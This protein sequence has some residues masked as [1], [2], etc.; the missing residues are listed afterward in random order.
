MLGLGKRKNPKKY[1][2]T[3]QDLTSGIVNKEEIT[4]EKYSTTTKILATTTLGIPGYLKTK[5]NHEKTRTTFDF[6]E[7]MN[8]KDKENLLVFEMIF[9]TDKNII[10]E[11]TPISEGLSA[12]VT[13]PGVESVSHGMLTKGVATAAFGLVGLAMTV[14][15]STRQRR[16]KTIV[17]IAKKGIIIK[18]ATTDEQDI[19]IP[20]NEIV[21]VDKQKGIGS[22]SI[23]ITL[24]NGVNITANFIGPYLI[25]NFK[26][27]TLTRR[28]RQVPMRSETLNLLYDY[29]N[30][31]VCG[32][33]DDGWGGELEQPTP[34]IPAPNPIVCRQCGS[35]L[36]TGANFCGNCGQP[37]K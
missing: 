11:K 23:I 18:N 30:I 35:I 20:W 4:E 21:S 24:T 37:K 12:L 19:R 32:Q 5:G 26:T 28:Y 13:L 34:S 15:Q 3:K 2:D 7:G 29:I 10:D 25:P 6:P 31:R 14:G 22:R 9:N 8:D 27:G 16:L 1:V 36:E 33:V 17:R